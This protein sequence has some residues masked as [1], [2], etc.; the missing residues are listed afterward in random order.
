MEQVSEGAEEREDGVEQAH[1]RF[2]ILSHLFCPHML[3]MK[4]V[5]DDSTCF[6]Y[7]LLV[8]LILFSPSP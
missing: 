3:T 5:H 8:K 7:D 2:P 4:H 6:T 1:F